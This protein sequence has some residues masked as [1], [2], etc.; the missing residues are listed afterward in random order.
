[1]SRRRITGHTFGLGFAMGSSADERKAAGA[2]T[3][4]AR[5][6]IDRFNQVVFITLFAFIIFNKADSLPFAIRGC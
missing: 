2:V 6:L 1:V 3:T 5:K 4:A